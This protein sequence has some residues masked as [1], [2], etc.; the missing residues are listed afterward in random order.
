M[1]QDSTE[2]QREILYGR[3]IIEEALLAGKNFEEVYISLHFKGDI[4]VVLKV[5]G[6]P[7]RRVR[8]ETLSKMCGTSNHQGIVGVTS[9]F[10][11]YS[12][13]EIIKVLDKEKYPVVLALDE[14]QDPHNLGAILRS[15]DGAG[16]SGVIMGER[17]TAPLTSV[18]AKASSGAVFHLKIARVKNL[19]S[20]IHIMKEKGFWIFGAH[21]EGERNYFEVDLLLPL[22]LVVG[23]EG[24]GLRGNIKKKCDLLLRIPMKG[25]TDSLNV[26]VATAIILYEAL[27]QRVLEDFKE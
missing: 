4:L 25:K 16:V 22:L 13:E 23:S 8:E 5:N 19:L 7:V 26:S 20:V 14:I 9:S 10:N 1:A 17:R 18:V 15:A 12:L 27:K 21:P 24:K 6:I 11:Y 3:R 2:I